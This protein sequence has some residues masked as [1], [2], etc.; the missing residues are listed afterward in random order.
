M[1]WI[2]ISP[3]HNAVLRRITARRCAG[4]Y[5][6]DS[7]TPP[8]RPPGSTT[9]HA[10]PDAGSTL[11]MLIGRCL[12]KPS[13]RD[14]HDAGRKLATLLTRYANDPRVIVLALPRGGVPVAV[15]IAVAL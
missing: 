2:S 8:S 13:F 9:A 7:D 14:R 11:R 1:C 12:M 15:E 6:Y 4:R 5:W 10:S 3:S